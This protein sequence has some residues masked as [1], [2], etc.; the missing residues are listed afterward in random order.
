MGTQSLTRPTRRACAPSRIALLLVVC[1][2][3]DLSISQS[4]A[5]TTVSAITAPLLLP[6]A[7]VFDQSGDLYIA[8]TAN[9]VIRKVNATGN[10]TT[11][12]GNGTQGFSGDNG[13]AT[14]AQ[15][16]SPQGLALDMANNLYIAD[17]HNHVIRKLSLTTGIL[18]TIAGTGAPGFTGDSG[19]ATRAQLDLPTRPCARCTK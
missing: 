5:Q 10:M 15:L 13:S 7:V 8:E 18:T 16:D 3:W 4:T 1:I 9:H 17:T 19:P 14:A 6:S 12:A 2:L 11:I